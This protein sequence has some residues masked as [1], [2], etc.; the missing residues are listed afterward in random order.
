MWAS[1]FSSTCWIRS[2]GTVR[3]TWRVKL[4]T[5]LQTDLLGQLRERAEGEAIK[6]FADNLKDLL[7][8]APAGPRATIGLD[9]GLRTLGRGNIQG[10]ES[11]LISGAQRLGHEKGEDRLSRREAP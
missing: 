2:R 7:L 1:H 3:W 9:P 6:V 4:L 5:H 8:A 10:Y 11:L